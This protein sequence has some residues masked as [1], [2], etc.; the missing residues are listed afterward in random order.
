MGIDEIKKMFEADKYVALSGIEILSVSEESAS[1]GAKILPCHLNANGVV[2]GGMLYTLADFAFAV[3]ANF[4]HPVSVSQSGHITYIAPADTDYITA[5][6]T[7]LVRRGH[8]SVCQVTVRGSDGNIICT[9]T[10][11]GF[12][13]TQAKE[14]RE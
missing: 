1:V 13:K 14:G 10:F 6:A 8:N 9:A 11:N 5:T 7:E 4:L 3:H 12:I 2:Q